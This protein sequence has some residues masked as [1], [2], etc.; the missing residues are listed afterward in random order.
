M[1]LWRNPAP[2]GFGQI[3]AP[4]SYHEYVQREIY[5]Q[6]YLDL[7]I[8]NPIETFQR[9]RHLIPGLFLVPI[10]GDP[11]LGALGIP[12]DP[13]FVDVVGGIEYLRVDYDYPWP[14]TEFK[15]KRCVKFLM[16]GEA[17]PILKPKIPL[18]LP[19]GGNDNQNAFFYNKTH[20]KGTNWLTEPVAAFVNTGIA[21]P[22]ANKTARLLFLANCSYYLIDLFPFAINYSTDF[23]AALNDTPPVYGVS[24]EF[25]MNY[26]IPK[27]NLLMASGLFCENSIMAFS[28]PPKIHHH[29]IN[30]INNPASPL[31][32]PAGIRCHTYQNTN[33]A[34]AAPPVTPLPPVNWNQPSVPGDLLNGDIR[35]P[36]D[37]NSVPFYR[38]LTVQ[39]AQAGPH[40]LFIRNAF[41][42]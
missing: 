29:L 19:Y 7:F 20:T 39:N 28:G 16:I 27:I 9:N 8:G 32:I 33:L 40:E 25:Y 31:A 38:C 1:A 14:R 13:L 3:I 5:Q 12:P 23:R 2:A 4:P 36:C 34:P 35:Y 26:L 22:A 21:A 11:H 24:E 18:G 15:K 30:Q 37:F 42:I 17:A 6:D 41:G 10:A